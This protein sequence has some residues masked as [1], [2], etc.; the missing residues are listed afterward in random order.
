MTIANAFGLL[1][2][3]LILQQTFPH[4]L[5]G[6][7][8]LRLI[9]ILPLTRLLPMDQCVDDRDCAEDACVGI[10]IGYAEF[11]RRHFPITRSEEET[12]KCRCWWSVAEISA[13]WPV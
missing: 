7:F 13:I 3:D 9:D 5:N 6:G 1:S 11:H 12:G 2:G 8:K 4:Q 10:H